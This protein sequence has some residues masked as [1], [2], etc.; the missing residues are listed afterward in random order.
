MQKLRLK[1]SQIFESYDLLKSQVNEEDLVRMAVAFV[2]QSFNDT[3]TT[4]FLDKVASAGNNL[5]NVW[6]VQEI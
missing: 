4:P 5:A 1:F 2:I 3:S 6:R